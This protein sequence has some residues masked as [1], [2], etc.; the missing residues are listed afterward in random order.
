[1][2]E[3]VRTD[4]EEL[5]D[6]EETGYERFHWLKLQKYTL[7]YSGTRLCKPSLAGARGEERERGRGSNVS[8][9]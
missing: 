1:M 5:Q 6:E 2:E 3:G 8:T 7:E 4:E 9:S